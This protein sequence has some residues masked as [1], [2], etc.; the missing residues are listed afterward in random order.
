VRVA[1]VQADNTLH[2]RPVQIGRDYGDEVE[3]LSDLATNDVI[4]TGIAGNI[5]EGA[6]VAVA[7]TPVPAS[8]AATTPASAPTP[9]A[10]PH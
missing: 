3:V 5:M 4:V 9:V 1:V 2:Y 6:T 8:A 10:T 7:K